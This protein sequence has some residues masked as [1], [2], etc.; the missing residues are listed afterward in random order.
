MFY[1]EAILPDGKVSS[2]EW[3]KHP[4]AC[5]IVPIFENGDIMMINQ[6]RY[7]VKQ[8]FLEVPAGKID[9][10]ENPFETAKRELIEETGINANKFHY[11]GHFYPAIGYADEIIHVF[12]ATGLSEGSKEADM[13]EFLMNERIFFSDAIKLIHK[14]EITDGK[15][16]V[17]LTRVYNWYKKVLI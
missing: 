9:P 8:I 10:N 13:D 17:S 6:F 11:T 2:R 4:G 14:G 1:D 5:A 12:A 15:T 7:P 3:I 16:I